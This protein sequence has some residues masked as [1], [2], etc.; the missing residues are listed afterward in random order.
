MEQAR[1]GLGVD[2]RP[3]IAHGK[4]DPRRRLLDRPDGHRSPLR[5]LEGIGGEVQ[6]H[7]PQGEGMAEPHVGGGKRDADREALL[8]RDRPDDVAHRLEQLGDRQR[9]QPVVR[10]LVAAAGQLDRIA[11]ER[12]QA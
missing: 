4:P 12:A 10:Q 2:A 1:Q 7:A 6:E 8:G 5:E 3:G 9:R 11:R